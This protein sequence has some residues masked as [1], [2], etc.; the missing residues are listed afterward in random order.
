M[1]LLPGCHLPSIMTVHCSHSGRMTT[2]K[3][4]GFTGNAIFFTLDHRVCSGDTSIQ[5]RVCKHVAVF[6][7]NVGPLLLLLLCSI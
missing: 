7:M 3:E 5:H 4:P 1:S 6:A 2:L